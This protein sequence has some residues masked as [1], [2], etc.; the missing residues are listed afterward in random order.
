MCWACPFDS[1]WR[2]PSKLMKFNQFLWNCLIFMIFWLKKWFWSNL[3]KI[4][5][6]RQFESKWH[7]EQIRYGISQHNVLL[8]STSCEERPDITK[9]TRMR[10][11]CLGLLYVNQNGFTAE[12]RIRI[13]DENSD[14]R[15]FLGLSNTDCAKFATRT[16]ELD[17]TNV[18]NS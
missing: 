2:V 7:V 5:A 9:P 15:W 1:D 8:R 10:Y 4:D 3:E 12:T 18:R 11:T 6:T 14:P 16:G 17:C 13:T